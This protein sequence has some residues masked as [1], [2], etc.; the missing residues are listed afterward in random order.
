MKAVACPQFPIN[1]F[2]TIREI[3]LTAAQSIGQPWKLRQWPRRQVAPTL[4]PA[5]T[6][7]STVKMYQAAL[8]PALGGCNAR[9]AAASSTPGSDEG[10]TDDVI[11][12]SRDE[13]DV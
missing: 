9:C 10:T 11:D 12:I 2:D 6:R 4:L 3:W 5:R 1:R 7:C 8:A 13:E